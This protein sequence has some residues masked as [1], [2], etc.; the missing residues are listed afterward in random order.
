MVACLSLPLLEKVKMKLLIGVEVSGYSEKQLLFLREI[1]EEFVR[2][3]PQRV[4]I[5]GAHLELFKEVKSETSKCKSPPPERSGSLEQK[6]R[7]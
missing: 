6:D 5:G 4:S 3:L 1:A 2:E 7:P